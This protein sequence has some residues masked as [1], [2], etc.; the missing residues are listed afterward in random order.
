MKKIV[1]NSFVFNYGDE[2]EWTKVMYGVFASYDEANDALEKLNNIK[3]KYEP[4]IE[5]LD[6]KQKLYYKYNTYNPLVEIK[7]EVIK[8]EPNVVTNEVEG[9]FKETFL[10]APANTF[11]INLATLLDEE[12]VRRFEKRYKNKIKFF[13]FKFGADTTYYKV[14]TGVFNSKSEAYDSIENLDDRLKQNKPRVENV[15]IKQKL[16][17]KYNKNNIE[18]DNIVEVE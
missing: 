3:E 13:I 8:E 17:F 14:M 10:N 11:S 5:L 4:I 18:Q 7:K 1:K 2:K 15:Q 9:D 16:Y 6:S 12:S